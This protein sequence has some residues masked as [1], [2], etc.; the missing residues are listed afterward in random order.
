MEACCY[1]DCSNLGAD[2]RA[3]SF[4]F[5]GLVD[6]SIKLAVSNKLLGFDRL[7]D[8][9]SL[10]SESEIGGLVTPIVDSEEEVKPDLVMDGS[11]VVVEEVV[12]SEDVL[13]N[14]LDSIDESN[15]GADDASGDLMVD[16]NE[17]ETSNRPR[18]SVGRISNL[19]R[20]LR[21]ALGVN[22]DSSISSA[23]SKDIPQELSSLGSPKRNGRRL[24]QFQIRLLIME[25]QAEIRSGGS[26]SLKGNVDGNGDGQIWG[27]L[28]AVGGGLI[29]AK[30][31]K[32]ASDKD[33]IRG[34]QSSPLFF[35]FGGT[36]D[37]QQEGKIGQGKTDFNA[38][39]GDKDGADL[40]MN[41][42]GSVQVGVN[43]GVKE[44]EKAN[45]WGFN[46]VTLADKI[47]GNTD[48]KVTLRYKAPIRLEDGRQVIR[49]SKEVIMEGAKNNSMLIVA[50][51]VGA[52]MPFFVLNNNLNRLWRRCGL[53]NVASNYK[54][55]YLLK[56]NNE[57]GMKYV[58]ENGPW[59]INGVPLF[60]KKWEVGY[61]L[62][63]PDLKKLPLWV[64]LYGVP[65]EV[66][67]I[68]G[69]S[70]LASG[71]GVP[72]ALDRATEERCLKQTGRAGFARVLIEVAAERSICDE[73]V[74]LVPSLD[75]LSEKEVVVRAEYNWKPPRC[76]HCSTFGH[77]FAACGVRPLSEAEKSVKSKMED[78]S[79]GKSEDDGFQVVGKR[80]KPVTAVNKGTVGNGQPS[81]TRVGLI[82]DLGR[83]R[84]R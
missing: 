17:K 77:S 27:S 7:S 20:I 49:F 41:D 83:E 6:M 47:R 54:G 5:S 22:M 76:S 66:W 69:L 59:M 44:K 40:V 46:G 50:H 33:G 9:N 60:V 65:L 62:E 32:M 24:R 84:R 38:V 37:D 30:D 29:Q 78:K 58:L 28:K 63:K 48:S 51:F 42:A 72:L 10:L 67:N 25:K 11:S 68:Q 75:G 14:N 13:V 52:S 31:R 80:N 26:D 36:V 82:R 79:G 81:S 34:N 53:V 73:V 61:Y 18:G 16:V 74:C 2:W 45:P 71:I 12:K 39:G 23:I 3:D 1:L 70:E 55:Y 4:C 15:I 64:N 19:T 43:G 21:N 8:V 56:F 35:S 57:E